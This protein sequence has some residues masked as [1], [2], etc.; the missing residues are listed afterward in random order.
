MMSTEVLY[1]PNNFVYIYFILWISD[2]R[3]LFHKHGGLL[4]NREWLKM[5]FYLFLFEDV[6]ELGNFD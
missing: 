4:S 5:R 3:K 2:Y 6:A 1:T